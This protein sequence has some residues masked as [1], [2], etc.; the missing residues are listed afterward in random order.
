MKKIAILGASYLQKPLVEKAKELGFET[1]CFAWDNDQAVCK[2][3]ADYFHPISVLDKEAILKVCKEIKIDGITTIATD[4]CI[5]SISYVANEM[6]LVANSIESSILSTNKAKMREAFIVN[7]VNCPKFFV[8]SNIDHFN[9]DSI[10]FP[11][12]LKPT[13][14]SGSRGVTKVYKIKEVKDAF[15]CALEESIEKKVII[16]EYIEGKEVSVESISWKGKHY[17]L[18]ITDKVTTG[19]PHFVELEHHQPAKISKEIKIKIERQVLRALDSLKIKYGAG[20]SEFKILDNGEV[21]AV[22]VAS[23]MGGDFIGSHLVP[24]STGY[25]FIQGVINVAVNNFETPV[26]SN[27]G[28][29]GVYFL[30]LETNTLLPTFQKNNDFEVEKE[31]QSMDLKFIKNSNDRCGYLIYKSDDKIN[32]R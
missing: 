16:E 17:I 13:D 9:W 3:I 20:H 21:V 11:I 30:S 1:H 25:D 24:L 6:N 10:S 19:E 23:R 4:I 26:I 18:A 27:L 22:E 12:I 5:P 7:N 28:Y 31:I 8:L 32:L 15:N 2:V 29:S 14:R